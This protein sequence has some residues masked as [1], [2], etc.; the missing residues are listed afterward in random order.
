MRQR[1]RLLNVLLVGCALLL[2]GPGLIRAEDHQKEAKAVCPICGRA[3]QD[4]GSYASKASYTLARGAS[5][6]LFGWTELIHTPATEVKRGGNVFT[7][8]AKGLGYGLTRTLA[9]GGEVLTFWTPKVHGTYLH[10]T[11]N[12]PVCRGKIPSSL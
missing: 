10:F 8:I 7:G 12:C 3:N 4:S 2:G 5:N 1:T 9:G 11:N 6:T